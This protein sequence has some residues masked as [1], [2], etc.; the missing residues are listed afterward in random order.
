MRVD[1][2][3]ITGVVSKISELV[4]G[5]RVVPGLIINIGNNEMSVCCTVGKKSFIESIECETDESDMTGKV[6]I[7][8]EQFKRAIDN[9]QPSGAIVVREIEITF[10]SG[11]ILKVSAMQELLVDNNGVPEYRSMARKEMDISYCLVEGSRDQRVMLLNRTNYNAMFESETAPDT[12]DRVELMNILLNMSFEKGKVVYLS[13]KTQKAFV[14]NTAFTCATPISRNDEAIDA[15]FAAM[16]TP[17]GVD[18][19]SV[20]N[21]DTG[22]RL[23]YAIIITA[24]NAK[25]IAGALS[26]MK[27]ETVKM[28]KKADFLFLYNENE[29]VAVGFDT[30][31]GS[32][33]HTN[34]FNTFCSLPYNKYQIT[35]VREFLADSIKSALASSKSEKIE[36]SFK[37][38]SSNINGYSMVINSSNSGSNIN[39]TYSVELDSVI[40]IGGTLESD[41]ITMSLRVF[42]DMLSQ[43]KTTMVAFDIAE[44]QSGQ[45]CLRLAELDDEKVYTE[46]KLAR[47]E[48]GLGEDEPTPLEVKMGYREKTL[49]TCQ[50]CM[51]SR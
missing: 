43:L 4:S 50:Y 2:S 31:K 3:T 33:V 21:V 32:S 42:S 40:D 51:I 19:S 8:Y 34:N 14:V 10:A 24:L 18:S 9:C 12:W 1:V 22:K 38:S 36:L 39:D 5:E 16:P 44:I 45:M 46:W 27:D 47:H 49:D 23:T 35:F 11:S 20:E 26:K 25:C 17:E 13:P 15:V 30:A 29:T 28:F 41:R 48:L 6:F 37:R 7:T